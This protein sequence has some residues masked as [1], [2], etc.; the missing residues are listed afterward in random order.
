MRPATAIAA[1]SMSLAACTTPAPPLPPAPAAAYTPIP[2]SLAD[3]RAMMVRT[4]RASVLK[5]APRFDIAELDR[6]LAVVGG[7]AREDFI[8]KDARSLAYVDVPLNIGFGQTI[9]DPYIVTVMTAA[10]HVPAGGNV[11]DIGTGS[12]YQAAVLGRM[13]R[14][15]VSIEIVPELAHAAAQRLRRQGYANIDVRAGDGFAGSPADAP[16]DAVIVAAG[17]AAVPTPLLDQLKPGGRLVM[18]IGPSTFQEQILVV[19]KRADGGFDRC[20]LGP[21]SFVALTGAGETPAGT[22]GL[23]DHTIP[24]CYGADVTG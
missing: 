12:G 21:A 5:S 2:A 1:L 13:V 9:S 18:P 15:V 14:R 4:I 20:S 7:I 17:A 8:A 10:A 23:Y 16:F 24:L 3:R 11:L 6:V 22:R 19:T